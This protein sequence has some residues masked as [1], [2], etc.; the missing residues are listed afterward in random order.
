MRRR[1]FRT[2]GMMFLFL[3]S[4]AETPRLGKHIVRISAVSLYDNPD[5]WTPP[6]T[7][8]PSFKV[9]VY[10]TLYENKALLLSNKL[11]SRARMLAV[12]DVWW[13]LVIFSYVLFL[14]RDLWWC[15]VMVG[16]IWWGLVIVGFIWWCLVMVGFFWRCLVMV[17][18]V[19]WCLA[20]H[21]DIYWGLIICW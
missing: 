19:W 9:S 14:Y 6:T 8:K 20:M 16:F 5:I 2:H 12:D 7:W 18:F 21:D 1:E 4:T 13:C 10:D 15:L 17:G 11:S 3:H